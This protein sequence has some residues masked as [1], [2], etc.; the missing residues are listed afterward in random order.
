MNTVLIIITVGLAIA[1]AS[2]FVWS[3]INTRKK[4]YDEYL[5]RNKK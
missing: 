1:G 2:L 5:I 3:I 4:F